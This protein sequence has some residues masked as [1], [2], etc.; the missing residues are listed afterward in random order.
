MPDEPERPKTQP[1]RIRAV[2]RYLV[3]RVL[4]AG[5]VTTYGEIAAATGI[6]IGPGGRPLPLVLHQILHWCDKEGLPPLTAVVVQKKS[7]RDAGRHGTV[8]KGY[9]RAEAKSPNKAGRFRS[10]E[11]IRDTAANAWEADAD[12]PTADYRSMV[13]RHQDAVWAHPEWPAEIDV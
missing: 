9:L 2:Y 3:R 8:G 11:F 7:E 10:D 13:D 12:W 5:R 4:P 6:R 1:D